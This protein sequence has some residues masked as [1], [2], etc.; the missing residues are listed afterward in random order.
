MHETLGEEIQ[1]ILATMDGEH[2]EE[3]QTIPPEKESEPQE[4]YHVYR[5]QGGVFI[6]KEEDEETEHTQVID[7]TPAKRN[8]DY[9]MVFIAL[10]C[11][12]PMLASITF[13]VYLIF[14]PPT[15]SVT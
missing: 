1:P 6:L 10:V 9:V 8:H 13:Q 5:L 15:V 12:L 14:N 11:C 7:G 3:E 2:T 4:I